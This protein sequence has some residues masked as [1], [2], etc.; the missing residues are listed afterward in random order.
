MESIFEKEDMKKLP[1]NGSATVAV[2]S[3]N[4]QPSHYP[5]SRPQYLPENVNSALS[6][7]PT[8]DIHLSEFRIINVQVFTA[9][10]NK[11]QPR[12]IRIV[13][14]LKQIFLMRIT[15][16]VSS[17]SSV[18]QGKYNGTNHLQT[19]P[20]QKKTTTPTSSLVT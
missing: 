1:R 6:D 5:H 17:P 10:I 12:L 20:W 11:T 3:M 16:V 18:Q 7:L 8:S 9:N 13:R 19:I 2:I 14:I 4:N 15:S